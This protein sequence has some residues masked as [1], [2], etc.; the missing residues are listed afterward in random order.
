ME[1]NSFDISIDD[2]LKIIHYQ[3]KGL[4]KVDEVLLAWQELAGLKEFS[5]DGYNLMCD[6]SNADFDFSINSAEQIW[7]YM[8]S[9]NTILQNKKEA[10]LTNKPVITAISIFFEN[11][12]FKIPNFQ[13]KTFST[14]D[15][16]LDWLSR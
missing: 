8:Y 12:S 5:L 4:L 10:I 1:R 15:V 13:L 7:N 6:Y 3:H 2:D 14:R 11:E 9:V 16:A